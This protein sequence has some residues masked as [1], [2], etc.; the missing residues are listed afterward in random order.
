VTFEKGLRDAGRYSR[1]EAKAAIAAAR[2]ALAGQRDA[3]D[4]ISAGAVA[5]E[6]VKNTL[7]G[8]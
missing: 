1:S 5:V 2:E 7:S 3:D 8:A 6:E 4:G